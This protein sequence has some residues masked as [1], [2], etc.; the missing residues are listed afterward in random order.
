MGA[1]N[2]PET[3]RVE[4]RFHVGQNNDLG[5]LLLKIER[6]SGGVPAGATMPMIN[7]DSWSG[8][9]D[10]RKVGICGKAGVRAGLV[11]ACPQ[12]LGAQMR[13]NRRQPEKAIGVCPASV[14]LIAG[15]APLKGTFA[16]PSNFR[17]SLNKRSA[18]NWPKPIPSPA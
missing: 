13:R 18:D 11:T 1:R 3:E 17:P 2:R 5:D 10:S 6:T 8:I 9:P 12:F 16:N 15:A 7:S 14:E 4:R